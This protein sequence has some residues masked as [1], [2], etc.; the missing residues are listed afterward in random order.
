MYKL[1][2]HI[3]FVLLYNLVIFFGL[4]PV[5]IADGSS[6]ERLST[7][8][9]VILIIAGLAAVHRILNRLVK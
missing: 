8:A 1:L 5:L 7:L 9:V 6:A 2:L 3:G 4:G